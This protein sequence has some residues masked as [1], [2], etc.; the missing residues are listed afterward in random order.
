MELAEAVAEG[1]NLVSFFTK[2]IEAVHAANSE[3][4]KA[5]SEIPILLCIKFDDG[6]TYSIL[7]SEDEVEIEDDEMIDFPNLT[8]KTK[9]S[10]F[11]LFLSY[12]RQ[13]IG[14][15]EEKKGEIAETFR[16]TDAFRDDVEKI[17]LVIELEVFESDKNVMSSEIILNDYEDSDFKR[18]KIRV[19]KTML[20][21]VAAGRITP[22]QAAKGLSIS[23]AIFKAAELGQLFLKHR[24]K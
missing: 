11:P 19:D 18:V 2:N 20:D 21:D 23:G 6:Q 5:L 10:E 12:V 16:L 9:A 15:F 22:A 8:V 24:L 1:T 7:M 14:A 3:D 17:D 4:F 13:Y